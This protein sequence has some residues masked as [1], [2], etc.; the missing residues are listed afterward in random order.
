MIEFHPNALCFGREFPANGAPCVVHV[1][2]HR[3]TI[4]FESGGSEGLAEE[5]PFVDL[6]VSAGGFD[7]DQLVL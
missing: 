6:T 4:T 1:D 2:D 5:V 3:L 7:H